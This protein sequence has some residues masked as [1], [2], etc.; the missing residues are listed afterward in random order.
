[1][2]EILHILGVLLIIVPFGVATFGP[3]LLDGEDGW[4]RR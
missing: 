2:L 1:M 4:N 3:L